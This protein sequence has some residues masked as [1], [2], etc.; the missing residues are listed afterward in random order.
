VYEE[1]RRIIIGNDVWI[2]CRVFIRDGVKIGHGAI[3]GAG[4]VVVS[5]VPAYAVVGG[6]PAKIIR[7]RFSPDIIRSLIDIEWWNWSDERLRDAQESFCKRD[8]GALI[9][10]HYDVTPRNDRGSVPN[11]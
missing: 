1:K 7:Y 11:N 3:I 10:P 2:G 4:A 6:V 9:R 8:A 5:D